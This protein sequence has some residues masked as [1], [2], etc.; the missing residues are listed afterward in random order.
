MKG[1]LRDLDGFQ[2]EIAAGNAKEHSMI[3]RRVFDEI[4][5]KKSELDALVE[6]YN[7][8]SGTTGRCLLIL[9]VK[10]I[11]CSTNCASGNTE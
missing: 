9:A 8:L 10:F 2:V 5:D 11:Q 7:Y 1:T 6:K 3:C 4:Q